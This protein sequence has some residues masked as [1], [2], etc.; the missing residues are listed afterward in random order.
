VSNEVLTQDEVDALLKGVSGDEEAPPQAGAEPVDGV[1]PY[2]LATQERI[3]RGRMPTLE[4]INDRFAR[5]LRIGLFNFM[6]RNPDIT[7]GPVKVIKYSEFLRNLAVPTNL[8]IIQAK[9]LRGSAVLVIE[10][11]LVFLSVD[12]MFGGAGRF[13]M[14]VEGRDFTPT[15]QRIIQRMLEVILAD[16]EK[17]WS[18]VHPLQFEYV[19]SEMQTQFVNIATPT[20]VVVVSTFNLELGPSGGGAFHV[21]MPYAMLEPIRDLLYSPMP[22]STEPDRRWVRMLSKQVQSAEVSL[23]AQLG[24]SDVRLRDL[25]NLKPG[26]VLPLDIPESIEATVDGVPVMQCKY[27]VRNGQYALRIERMLTPDGDALVGGS[28]A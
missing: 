3:V 18:S 11:A 24:T 13:H 27:G 14:R 1:R 25:M 15:E 23:V 9:P 20:E 26:D 12:T 22:D 8:N 5:L 17:A 7:I 21:C 6:R 16:Y 19:R 28:H 10:P 4:I 2:N